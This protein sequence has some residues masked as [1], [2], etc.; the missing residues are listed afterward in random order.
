MSARNSGPETTLL[1]SKYNPSSKCISKGKN[2]EIIVFSGDKTEEAMMA[3]FQ[4]LP[5]KSFEFV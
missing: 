4:K 5:F 1:H 2:F 3:Y